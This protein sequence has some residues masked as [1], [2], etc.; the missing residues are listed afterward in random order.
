M[1]K[2]SDMTE[3]E[4]QEYEERKQQQYWTEQ[5]HQYVWNV[6][7]MT[8]MQKAQIEDVIRNQ[9]EMK[10]IYDREKREKD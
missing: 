5:V 7:K 4:Y 3:E 1:K 10:E 2:P 9:N 6:D 8:A